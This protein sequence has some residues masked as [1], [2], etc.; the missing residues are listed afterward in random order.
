MNPRIKHITNTVRQ[1]LCR[2][3]YSPINLYCEVNPDDDA[4][5]YHNVCVKCGKTFDICVPTGAVIP[6]FLRK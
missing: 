2:H 5:Y 6:E 1:H 4:I 3:R